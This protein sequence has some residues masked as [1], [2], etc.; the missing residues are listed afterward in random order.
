MRLNSK[1]GHQMLKVV[2]RLAR[3]PFLD[4]FRRAPGSLAARQPRAHFPQKCKIATQI[5]KI[6]LSEI[7]PKKA[8]N[9]LEKT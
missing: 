5:I 1:I 2:V 7:S 3:F 6:P 9:F 4:P 8:H